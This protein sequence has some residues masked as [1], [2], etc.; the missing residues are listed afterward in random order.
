MKQ[1][2]MQIQILVK[3]YTPNIN[4]LICLQKQY[5]EKF[6]GSQDSSRVLKRS[7]GKVLE[8]QKIGKKDK[9]KMGRNGMNIKSMTFYKADTEEDDDG[10]QIGEFSPHGL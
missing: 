3:C 6:V 5:E 4:N 7:H 2:Q 8:E 1:I 10:E 9:S